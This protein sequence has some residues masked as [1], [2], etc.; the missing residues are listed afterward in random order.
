[1]PHVAHNLMEFFLGGGELSVNSGN[2]IN[3]WS[4]N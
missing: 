3:H 2:L 1:M 4:M